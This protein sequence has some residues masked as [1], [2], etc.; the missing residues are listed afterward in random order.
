MKLL[1]EFK[2]DK[3]SGIIFII[4]VIILSFTAVSGFITAMAVKDLAGSVQE[5]ITASNGMEDE[6]LDMYISQVTTLDL[7]MDGIG[8]AYSKVAAFTNLSIILL[9]MILIRRTWNYDK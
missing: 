1:D 8:N 3:F 4:V 2:K 5:Y 9:I 6:S 7:G